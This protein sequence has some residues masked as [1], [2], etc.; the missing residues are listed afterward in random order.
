MGNKKKSK[1]VLVKKA[2]SALINARRHE[3]NI[4]KAAE[5]AAYLAQ[6]AAQY[7]KK[8]FKQSWENLVFIDAK[9]E[10]RRYY[11]GDK[12][13]KWTPIKKDEL[14]A[15]LIPAIVKVLKGNP[16]IW[17]T[18]AA[19]E[20][21]YCQLGGN[22]EIGNAHPYFL[23]DFLH[24]INF[25]WDPQTDTERWIQEMEFFCSAWE[26]MNKSE[27]VYQDQLAPILS[28]I[29]GRKV[30]PYGLLIQQYHKSQAA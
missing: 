18:F 1:K 28:E 12:F 15:I 8:F 30:L 29:L 17:V 20:I 23:K 3:S 27:V 6:Q 11:I 14:R 19:L 4:Q 9:F 10:N 13:G 24:E 25:G 21:E 5:K 2:R 16:D 7:W 22:H 26:P